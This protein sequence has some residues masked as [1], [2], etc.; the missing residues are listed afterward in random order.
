M[1]YAGIVAGGSGTRMGA[2]IPKQYIEICGKPII[3]R[4]IEKFVSCEVFRKIFVAVPQDH[5]S[6]TRK[7]IEK[8]IGTDSNV[9]VIAG[10]N[11]RNGSVC[12][13]ISAAK[14]DD[15]SPE[16]LLVTH[17]GVRPFV[18][19]QMIKE[20]IIRAE[21]T[22]ASGVYVPTTD[23][24]VSSSDGQ[25]ADTVLNRALLYNTQTP[26][27]FRIG[28]FE[29]AFSSLSDSEK[30]TLTDVSGLFRKTGQPVAMVMGSTGNIKITTPIDIAVAEAV[31]RDSEQ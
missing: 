23:T 26:Q 30:Q 7:L 20:C 1:V 10:G 3:I 17:D 28:L 25:F 8:H 22:G 2:P 4:T 15:P 9:F 6:M 11:D 31:I 27:T 19:T 16:N 29:E 13:I 24:I 5:I 12:N 14:A 21:E 18:T